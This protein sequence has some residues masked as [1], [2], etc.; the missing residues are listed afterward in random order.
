MKIDLN[1]IKNDELI[2]N[3]NIDSEKEFQNYQIMG[4]LGVNYIDTK[5]LKNS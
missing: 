2:L 5:K 3:I 4:G 1:Q